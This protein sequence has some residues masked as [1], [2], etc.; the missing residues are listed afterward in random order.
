[1]VTGFTTNQFWG[2]SGLEVQLGL[3]LQ[4]TLLLLL[5]ALHSCM[6]LILPQNLAILAH[7]CHLEALQVWQKSQKAAPPSGL[8]AFKQKNWDLPIVE[9]SFESLLK[10]GDAK[11]S[12][13]LLAACKK[14]SGMCMAY[15]PTSLFC[16]SKGEQ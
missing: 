4:L 14:E 7:P 11:A 15:S 2:G 6:G 10:D 8:S 1:M 16:R 5:A 9:A 12:A 3:H 13:R